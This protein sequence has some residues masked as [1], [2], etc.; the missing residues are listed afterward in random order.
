LREGNGD[1]NDEHAADRQFAEAVHHGLVDQ[2]GRR[3]KGL[4]SIKNAAQ[5]KSAVAVRA[6]A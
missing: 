6:A 4:V 5:I 1:Q 2:L 3:P